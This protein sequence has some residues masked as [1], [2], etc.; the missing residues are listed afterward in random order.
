MQAMCQRE[1]DAADVRQPDVE[2]SGTAVG[3]LRAEAGGPVSCC[4]RN[5]IIGPLCVRFTT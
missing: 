2:G 4:T 3:L 5:Q 1:V